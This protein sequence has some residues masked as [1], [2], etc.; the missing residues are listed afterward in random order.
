MFIHL[1]KILELQFH[2]DIKLKAGRSCLEYH[3]LF[4]AIKQKL[5]AEILKEKLGM[6]NMWT[7][8]LPG[9]LQLLN[10][11]PALSSSWASAAILLFF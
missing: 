8:N 4:L 2:V 3:L 11:D 6:N 1:Q 7:E 10:M 5:R 9:H